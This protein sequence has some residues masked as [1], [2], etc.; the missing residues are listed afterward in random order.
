MIPEWVTRLDPELDAIEN[1]P[2]VLFK[3]KPATMI[4][5]FTSLRA[6]E[7]NGLGLVEKQENDFLIPEVFVLDQ[8]ANEAEANM[9]GLAFNRFVGQCEDPSKILLQ[10]HSHD[11]GTVFWSPHKDIP[12]IKRWL[13]LGDFLI[14]MVVNKQGD[15]L[16]RLD[17]SKPFRLSVKV[18]VFVV[19]PF[20]AD[21]EILS[22]CKGEIGAKVRIIPE[23]EKIRKLSKLVKVVPKKTRKVKKFQKPRLFSGWTP[24]KRMVLVPWKLMWQEVKLL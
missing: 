22:F 10:W 19:V 2:R 1:Q 11:D 13:Q 14:S 16:C 20:K 23:I 3:L 7:I 21:Q 24:E 18:P 6:G 9:N 4:H 12:T 17:L 15:C 5:Y 8:E